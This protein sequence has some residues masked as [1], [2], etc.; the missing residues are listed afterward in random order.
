MPL[1]APLVRLVAPL[2]LAA[3]PLAAAEPATAPAPAPAAA[4]PAAS[5]AGAPP[6]ATANEPFA[7][8]VLVEHVAC[9]RDPTQTYTLY[10]P[11]T[12]DPA[13]R[14][15]ALL[16]F[17]PRGRSV[18]AAELFRE[19]AERWGWVILSSNDTRSDGPMDPNVKAVNALWPE[20]HLRYA[21]DPKRIYATGFSG[22]GMLAYLLSRS[23]G[24]VAGT[25]AASARWEKDDLAK[26]YPWPSFGTAGDTDFN[27]L[28][29][30][31]IHA[32]LE[33][34]HT[35][36]R[37]EVFS[38]RHQWM[39]PE[40]ASLAVDWLEL[41]A[42]RQGLRPKDDAAVAR[43]LAADRAAADGLAAA[44]DAWGAAHRYA[45]IAGT[46][47]GLADVAEAARLAST[48]AESKAYRERA[49]EEERWNDAERR[50]QS[51]LAQAL[52]PLG[53]PDHPAVTARLRRDL[54]VDDL[55]KQ[56]KKPGYEG[57]VGRRLLEEVSSQVGFYVLRDAIARKAW[58]DAA[59]LIEIGVEI[60]PERFDL[61]YDRAC[62]E[63]RLGHRDDAFEHLAKAVET[64][65]NH[66]DATAADPD[67]ESLHDDPRWA[68]LLARM[69]PAAAP[70]P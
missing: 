19:A 66:P 54:Q 11:T 65:W 27:Y 67:L 23:T 34:A 39:P 5:T 17:D 26:P 15:P 38:G 7:K 43:L 31:E 64:G 4:A 69:Q 44:G 35:P 49:K 60:H 40:L 58:R 24:Q 47:D 25:I 8:G 57:V 13:K 46:Y 52:V 28:P 12:Y 32:A 3:A 62:V 2:L 10:L 45:A 18:L 1:S 14:A 16:V 56:A 20:V 55:R 22:G 50:Y 9:Q 63:A 51:T 33:R 53:D 48:L 59:S 29:M 6:A 42:M 68:P 37:L 30:Q 36:Q 21:T 61:W 70:Q 41:R